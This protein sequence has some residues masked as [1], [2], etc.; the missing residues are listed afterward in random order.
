M[1]LLIA[2]PAAAASLAY[3]NARTSFGLDRQ[4]LWASYKGTKKVTSREKQD[5]LNFF[6]TLEEHAQ[7]RQLADVTFLWYEGQEWTYKQTYDIVLKYGTWLK[8]EHGV[9]P[10][11]IVAM[12]MMNSSTY[13]FLWFGIWSVGATPAFINYNLTRDSLTQCVNRS[14]A[15][16]LLVGD[17]LRTLVT[18]DVVDKLGSPDTLGTGKDPVKVVF[19]TLEIETQIS[20]VE[21]IR[22]PDE[23]RS[24]VKGHEPAYLI[25]TSGTT[26]LP[27]PAI[28]PWRTTNAAPHIVEL[29]LG[30]KRSDRIYTVSLCMA[31]ND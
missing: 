17:D 25:F 6:Y 8:T 9:K 12:D 3:L 13:I 5:R 15:K 7:S 28:V 18:Q 29:A 10:K 4:L 2:A 30:W 21:G 26:G 23:C 1:S 24:N 11:D 19:M 31:E 22:E 16:L 20:H 14:T 27:K